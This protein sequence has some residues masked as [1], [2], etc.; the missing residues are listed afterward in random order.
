MLPVTYNMCRYPLPCKCPLPSSRCL[1]TYRAIFNTLWSPTRLVLLAP[2]S[3]QLIFVGIEARSNILAVF[4][5]P[6][7]VD[8]VREHVMNLG[9]AECSISIPIAF[10]NSDRRCWSETSARSEHQIVKSG[11]PNVRSVSNS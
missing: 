9:V 7:H 4:S 5:V 10:R 3:G 8:V 6:E 2:G 11:V 1:A